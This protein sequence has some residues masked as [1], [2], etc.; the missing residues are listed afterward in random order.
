M[1]SLLDARAV[2]R[3]RGR[4]GRVSD[5]WTSRNA[6]IEGLNVADIWYGEYWGSSRALLA[7]PGALNSCEHN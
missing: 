6:E 1:A 5:G 2:R 3:L 7:Y 4:F